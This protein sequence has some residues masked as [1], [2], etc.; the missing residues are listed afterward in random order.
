ML[1]NMSV[2]DA[3]HQVKKNARK[4]RLLLIQSHSVKGDERLAMSPAAL[5]L[6]RQVLCFSAR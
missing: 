5:G 2:Y 6:A 1:Q 4:K 3:Y